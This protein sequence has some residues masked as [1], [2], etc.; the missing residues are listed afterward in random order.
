MKQQLT[1]ANGKID[2]L[3]AANCCL[4]E[5]VAQLQVSSGLRRWVS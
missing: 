3:G 5:E 2:E 4:K 1:S